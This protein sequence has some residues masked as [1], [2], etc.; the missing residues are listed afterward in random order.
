MYVYSPIDYF[1][2]YK[3]EEDNKE[4]IHIQIQCTACLYTSTRP[5]AMYHMSIYMYAN[6]QKRIREFNMVQ[7][8][9]D[10]CLR[11]ENLRDFI[12][13]TWYKRSNILLNFHKSTHLLLEFH[14]ITRVYYAP[15]SSSLFLS[16]LIFLRVSI[17]QVIS[18]IYRIL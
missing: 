10:I 13:K 14:K 4:T 11:G 5:D 3:R 17:Y 9:L 2:I 16:F 6:K 15:S 8:K 18:F 12:N 1:N 7:P